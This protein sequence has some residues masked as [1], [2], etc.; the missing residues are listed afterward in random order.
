MAAAACVRMGP[1]TN[2]HLTLNP[3]LQTL[4]PGG[5]T[6]QDSSSFI[7]APFLLDCWEPDSLCLG[8]FV[9]C[10]VPRVVSAKSV[11]PPSQGSR[12]SLTGRFMDSQEYDD[13]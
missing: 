7:Q 1:G 6:T 8:V 10:F 4:N 3:K 12:G 9:F 5:K 13:K 11:R 2:P